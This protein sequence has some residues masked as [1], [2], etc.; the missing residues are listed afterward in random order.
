LAF[1]V[2]GE[3]DGLQFICMPLP[4]QPTNFFKI[5][6]ASGEHHGFYVGPATS[7]LL[8][9]PTAD[10]DK[11]LSLNGFSYKLY[12]QESAAIRFGGAVALQVQAELR[13]IGVDSELI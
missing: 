10:A 11:A 6:I 3:R 5:R 2:C 8:T 4:E 1:R 9:Q 12:T 7:G 13:D